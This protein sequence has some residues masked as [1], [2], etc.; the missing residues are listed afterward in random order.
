[1]LN[2]AAIVW[3][4]ALVIAD[5]PGGLPSAAQYGIAGTVF[6]VLIV[7][8]AAVYRD[9]LRREARRD[10]LLQAKDAEL[11]ALNQYIVETVVPVLVR[12]TDAS[13]QM[14]RLFDRQ[15]DTLQQRE[16]G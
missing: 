7:A 9:F 2:L 6:T 14:A 13:A 8:A 4:L 10:A 1:M 16:R 5:E 3:P 11:K 15:V 12:A